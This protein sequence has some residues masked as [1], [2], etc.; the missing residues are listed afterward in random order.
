MKGIWRVGVAAACMLGVASS[1]AGAATATFEGACSFDALQ[2]RQN[3]GLGPFEERP[4]SATMAG[5]GL[6]KGTINGRR[7][8]EERVSTLDLRLV[9]R[10]SCGNTAQISGPG[11]FTVDGV[12]FPVTGTLTKPNPTIQVIFQLRGTDS[13]TADGGG[14]GELFGALAL[15]RP[16]RGPLRCLDGNSRTSAVNISFA[17]STPLM[18]TVPDAPVAR[19]ARLGLRAGDQR[20]STVLRTGVVRTHCT[21]L[22]AGRCSVQVVRGGRTLAKG[23]ATGAA[24]RPVVVR[25]RLTRAGRR[26]LRR[27]GPL[28]ATVRAS[29]T[30]TTSR[31]RT[32]VLR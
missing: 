24:G 6:C 7:I 30:G 25:A 10:G 21:V 3:E 28:R 22:A 26:A 32:F 11:T 18:S 23:S 14:S 27:G 29:A 9:G 8:D 2:L 5:P 15:Q 1:E 31:T 12:T 4:F 20:A 13:G 16:D 19:T 17:T